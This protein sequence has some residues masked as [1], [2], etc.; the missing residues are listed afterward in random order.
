LPE[1]LATEGGGP[2]APAGEAPA[3]AESLQP[4]GSQGTGG[5]TEIGDVRTVAET[6]DP[7][8]CA[9]PAGPGQV[10]GRAV[11]RRCRRFPR[12]GRCPPLADR[13]QR[14]CALRRPGPTPPHLTGHPPP[15]PTPAPPCL[16]RPR[17]LA[18]RPVP[19]TGPHHPAR[20]LP[21][22]ARW[23]PPAGRPRS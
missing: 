12:R 8:R 21:S 19:A 5:G 20:R 15:G 17:C 1:G 16:G 23:A 3:A 11:S 22:S 6:G 18:H 10:I 2:A 14:P 7:P 9:A 4:H 13:T